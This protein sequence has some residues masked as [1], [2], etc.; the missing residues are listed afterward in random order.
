MYKSLIMTAFSAAILLRGADAQDLMDLSLEDLLAIEVTSVAKK[1]QRVDEAAAAVAVITQEDIRKIGA[2]T[3][4]ELLRYVPGVEVGEI[5]GTSSAVSARGFN[6]RYANKLLVLIDGRALY[7]STQSGVL[8]DQVMFPV[9]DIDRIEIIRGPGATLYGANAVNGVINIV[10]KHAADTLGSLVAAQT[11]VTTT[12]DQFFGRF[13]A[14]QGI[15]LSD[16]GAMRLYVTGK[17]VPALVGSD[18][19]PVNSGA[20]SIQA[21]FRVDLEPNDKDSFTLQGDIRQLDF[22]VT[23][24]FTT[25]VGPFGSLV[26][27]DEEIDEGYNIL[28]RWTHSFSDDN[29][30]SVQTYID[31]SHRTEFGASFDYTSFDLDISQFIRWGERYE[32]VWGFGYRTVDDKVVGEDVLTYT[33]EEFYAELYN[34]YV[35][36]DIHFADK[37]L[38]FSLGSKFEHNDFTGFEIQPSARAIWVG[39]KDWSV[40]GAVSRAVRTPSRLETSINFDLGTVP[41]IP[42][43]GL[44][45]PLQSALVGSQ[46]LDAEDLL[47]FEAGWRKSWDQKF[48][49]DIAAYY[50]DYR[51][52]VA[53]IQLDPE[54]ITAPIGP[55]GAE[56]PVTIEQNLGVDNAREGE[57][58]GI[59]AS[60]LWRVTDQW[61]LRLVGDLKDTW[62]SEVPTAVGISQVFQGLSPNYQWNIRSDYQLTPELLTVTTLR[63]V[64]ELEGSPTEGYTDLDFRLAYRPRPQ[65]EFSL[66]GE[67]LLEAGRREFNSIIYPAPYSEVERKVSATMTLR[68]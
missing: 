37:R 12:A 65:M 2:T 34:G 32:T 42:E 50:N 31:D 7:Q 39:E 55:G 43:L 54:L 38:R 36:Q 16:N 4:P 66:I 9:E 10:T 25:P 67:N 62:F 52:L 40:W 57:V 59:E 24:E 63:G 51:E 5:D 60:A 48:E 23:L 3:V 49:L 46:T 17:D 26:F 15:R 1:P 22:D 8:W 64:G 21:G 61:E 33:V 18:E 35:Q 14:R 44:F 29:Q 28:G 47:A 6:Y 13:A 19:E 30:L 58:Y 41:P 45:L 68:F 53:L 56:V 11:G 27:E 20:Q